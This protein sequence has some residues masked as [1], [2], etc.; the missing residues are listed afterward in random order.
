MFGKSKAILRNEIKYLENKIKTL[1]ESV[2]T[3]R[4]ICSDK[5]KTERNKNF[6]HELELAARNEPIMIDFDKVNVW[7][8]E[9]DHTD[10]NNVTVV[11]VLEQHNDKG[12]ILTKSK[13]YRYN[14][15]SDGHKRI[16]AA[17]EVHMAK[18]EKKK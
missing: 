18:K 15:N 13:E 7:S 14:T 9:R 2:E 12:V 6:I 16:I 1:E 10:G 8:I 3:W 11:G 5:D 17:Y 4:R